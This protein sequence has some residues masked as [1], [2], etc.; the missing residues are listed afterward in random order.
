MAEVYGEKPKKFTR[1]WWPYFWLYYRWHVIVI[2]IVCLFFAIGI[3]Q[4]AKSEKYDLVTVYSGVRAISDE[5]AAKI[6]DFMSAYVDDIDKNGKQ[7][8]FFEQ[9]NVSGEKQDFQYNSAMQTR[10]LIEMQSET[11]FLYIMDKK[12]MSEIIDNPEVNGAFVPVEEWA[13][14]DL[15]EDCLYGTDGVNRAVS[16]KDSTLL[17]ETGFKCEDLYVFI[18]EN[19][20]DK[21]SQLYE[22]SVRI[23]NALLK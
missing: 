17:S 3:R 21:S 22:N 2:G 19:A 14:A 23:A 9:L 10:L 13:D 20:D 7:K 1:G 11:V 4:C 8:V 18:Q 12:Q 5:D 6:E 15:R 16:L